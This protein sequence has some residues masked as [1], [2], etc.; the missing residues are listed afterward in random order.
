M[1]YAKVM[2]LREEARRI[3]K[4]ADTLERQDIDLNARFIVVETIQDGRPRASGPL[5]WNEAEEACRN[6]LNRMICDYGEL[7]P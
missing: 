3:T 2:T 1:T 4:L 5:T 6:H 7:L